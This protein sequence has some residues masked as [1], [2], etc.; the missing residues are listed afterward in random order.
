MLT[1]KRWQK[2]KLGEGGYSSEYKAK[3]RS[4]RV[5]AI[6]MLGKSKTNGQDFINEVGPLEV[7]HCNV[8]RLTGL[9]V[10]GS[11]RAHLKKGKDIEIGDDETN[12]EKNIVKQ[13]MM[14]ALWCVQMRPSEHPPA[15]E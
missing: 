9:C 4:G 7:H 5:V 1:S 13:M 8:V 15:N 12:E 3:L 2:D 10:D 14:V 11:K 6:K